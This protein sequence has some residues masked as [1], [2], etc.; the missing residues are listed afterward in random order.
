[1]PLVQAT[2]STEIK[3]MMAAA[4]A[5]TDNPNAAQQEIADELAGIIINAIKSATI[6]IPTGGVV[7]SGTPATQSNLAPITLF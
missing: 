6:V 3:N 5:K 4:F 2:I 7:V 1:M